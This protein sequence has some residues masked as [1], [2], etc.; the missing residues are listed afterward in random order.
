MRARTRART[1]LAWLNNGYAY[2][3]TLLASLSSVAALLFFAAIA[4]ALRAVGV[5]GVGISAVLSVIPGFLALAGAT[6]PADPA[7]ADADAAAAKRPPSPLDG[8]TAK[9]DV[10]TCV[11]I[12]APGPTAD[13]NSGA[14]PVVLPPASPAAAEEARPAAEPVLLTLPVPVP[15]GLY[16]DLSGRA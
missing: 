1:Q 2:D 4:A 14:D 16:P 13:P 11:V 8:S 7:A 9:A 10:P 3:Y 5:E 6:H 12:L 15:A